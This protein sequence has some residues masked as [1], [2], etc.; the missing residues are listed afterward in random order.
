M[1]PRLVG[2]DITKFGRIEWAGPGAGPTKFDP[3]FDMDP[4][5]FDEELDFDDRGLDH[6][7][8]AR[9][10]PNASPHHED[11]LSPMEAAFG[12]RDDIKEIELDRM[13]GGDA[14]RL[15]LEF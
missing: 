13:F 1:A 5:I 7:P 9:N 14:L 6:D 15:E 10:A 8:R 4:R 3:D 11:R 12:R 2:M